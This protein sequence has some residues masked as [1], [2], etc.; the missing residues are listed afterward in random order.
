MR[1]ASMG[2][3]RVTIGTGSVL[4]MYR[5]SIYRRYYEKTRAEKRFILL[6]MA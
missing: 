6:F 4:P 2:G 3:K 5:R 1:A